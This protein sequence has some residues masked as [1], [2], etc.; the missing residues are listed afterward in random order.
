MADLIHKKKVSREEIKSRML[1]SAAKL[2]GFQDSEMDAFDPLVSLLIGSCATEFEKIDH[3][4]HASHARVLGRLAQLMTPDV[5]T[6]PQPS[7][8]ISQMRSV[9]PSSIIGRNISLNFKKQLPKR[10]Q[11]DRKKFKEVHFTPTSNFQIYD[12][13][14]TAIA[15]NH[16]IYLAENALHREAIAETIMGEQIG[17]LN[18]WI[19]LDLNKEIE[20]LE[21][22]SLYFDWPNDPNRSLYYQLLPYVKAFIG[23]HEISMQSGFPKIKLNEKEVEIEKLYKAYD[24]AKKTEDQVDSLFQHHYIHFDGSEEKFVWQ[25][26]L[27]SYPEEFQKSFDEGDLGDLKDPVLWIKLVFPQSF[28]VEALDNVYCGINCVPIINRRLNK[29]IHSLKQDINIVPLDSESLFFNVSLVQDS[30]GNTYREASPLTRLVHYKSLTYSLRQGNIG[31]YDERNASEM[32]NYLHDLLRDESASFSALNR[33]WLDLEVKEMKQILA[34]IEQKLSESG[35]KE[36]SAYLIVKPKEKGDSA[37]VNFWTTD[38]EFANNIAVGTR[39]DLDSGI[40]VDK[41]DII[42][43]KNTKGG[44]SKLNASESLFAYKEAVLTRG[45]VVTAEDIKTVC[46]AKL[47]N[48]IR[49]V[50]IT[51]GISIGQE[52]TSGLV[53][54]IEILLYPSQQS[55]ILEEEWEEICI[56]LKSNLEQQSTLTYPFRLKVKMD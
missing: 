23:T 21:N 32:T 48:Q 24:I 13:A 7:Y 12:G 56:N 25:N 50:E 29:L 39:L 36:S 54:T 22:L 27:K 15:A 42:I 2:W 18:L 34:R 44:R 9:E 33:D 28:P 14:I 8:S 17:A 53:R 40:D 55:K 52:K 43:I 26:H 30:N 35:R 11:E 19:G 10:S 46:F 45:R 4:I 20:S 51:K 47:G 1:K 6:G 38:G 31:R 49:K 41:K 37:Y 3:E 16:R 5:S